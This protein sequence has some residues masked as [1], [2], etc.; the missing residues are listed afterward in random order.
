MRPVR[1]EPGLPGTLESLVTRKPA[2]HMRRDF[3]L[4]TP[5]ALWLFGECSGVLHHRATEIT[6]KRELQG[7]RV[8][9]SSVLHER[10]INPIFAATLAFPVAIPACA[11][12]T[13]FYHRNAA[14]GSGFRLTT[15]SRGDASPDFPIPAICGIGVICGW[16]FA[17]EMLG[18]MGRA[19]NAKRPRVS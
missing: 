12:T 17:D 15:D 6:E 4:E 14:N 5:R 11:I 1:G 7:G 16:S 19:F 8:L 9:D 13:L 10:K 3:A 18:G 2:S